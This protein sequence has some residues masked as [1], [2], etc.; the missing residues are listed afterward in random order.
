MSV[1]SDIVFDDDDSSSSDND[2]ETLQTFHKKYASETNIHNRKYSSRDADDEVS[3][4]TSDIDEDPSDQTASYS[5]ESDEHLPKQNSSMPKPRENIK[6]ETLTSQQS[7]LDK[8]NKDN[9]E[10]DECNKSVKGKHRKQ[11][12]NVE[13]DDCDSAKNF[14]IEMGMKKKS[15]KYHSIKGS[16]SKEDKERVRVVIKHLEYPLVTTR[17]RA[18]SIIPANFAI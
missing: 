6:V 14:M 13:N 9:I 10:L 8:A 1:K 18:A 3:E 15:A 12:R 16:E 7:S 5:S 11:L 4:S 17:Y 2:L